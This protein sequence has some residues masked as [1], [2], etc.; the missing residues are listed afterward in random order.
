MKVKAFNRTFLKRYEKAHQILDPNFV[1]RI[2][3]CWRIAGTSW[4][5]PSIARQGAICIW[6][7]RIDV[8]DMY[9]GKVLEINTAVTYIFC[10]VEDGY[11]SPM[12]IR[13]KN[14]SSFTFITQR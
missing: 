7:L 4:A 3:S 2:A 13:L 5:T 10:Q 11:F 12:G 8:A 1:S 6:I 9:Y 14:E